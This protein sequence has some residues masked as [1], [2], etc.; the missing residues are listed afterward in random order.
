[1]ATKI[2]IMGGGNGAFAAAADLSLR[3][4]QITIYVNESHKSSIEDIMKTGIIHVVG[5]GPV[6]D[7]KIHKVTCD[8]AD[9]LSDVDIIMPIL[10]AN[11]QEN[12]AKS[13][14][15]YIKSGDKIVLTPGSTGGA[16]IFA[17]VLHDNGKIDGVKIAEMHT[18]PYATRKINSC[19]IDILLMCKMMFFAAFPAKHNQEMY[20]IVKEMYPLI[21]LVADVLETGLNNGNAV[22]HPAPVILNAGKIEYY[23]K[24]YHY[25][26]GITPSVAKVNE[27][28]DEERLEISKVFG[29]KAINARE[30]LYRMGYCP[31]KETLFESYQAST[32][33]FLPIEGPNDLNGRYLTEDVPCSLVAMVEVAR[34]AGVSTPVMDSV[35]ILASTLKSENYLESGRTLEK[36]GLNGMTI[37]EIKDLL[38]NGYR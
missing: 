10:P 6:G 11:A 3:G 19:T 7:A 4:F 24:H 1:M 29:Y 30:R 22:S 35:V 26:E 21:E 38:Q 12:M 17:K 32:T 2:C 14:L 8:L 28:I 16:L 37:D 15:P 9:A 18:L 34:L 31:M 5:V 33:V 20:D 27:K 23:G 25:R 36:M 13:L